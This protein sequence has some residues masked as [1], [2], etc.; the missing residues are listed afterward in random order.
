MRNAHGYGVITAPG[1]TCEYDTLTCG[2]CNAIVF[3]KPGSASTTYLLPGRLPDQPWREEPGAG[4]R[5]CMRA[6]CLR[7]CAEGRCTPL[8]A[9]IEAMEGK[10][11]LLQVVLGGV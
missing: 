6:I 7:C 8:E 2:H 3:T 11:R 9:R 5:V 1:V 4:C 10:R